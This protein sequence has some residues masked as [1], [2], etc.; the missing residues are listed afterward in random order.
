MMRIFG[1]WLISVVVIYAEEP[2]AC[3]LKNIA[4]C[5]DLCDDSLLTAPFVE[6]IFFHGTVADFGCLGELRNIKVRHQSIIQFQSVTDE[7]N[8]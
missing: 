1:L 2:K 5:W 6:G 4:D 3:L 8:Q 7:I